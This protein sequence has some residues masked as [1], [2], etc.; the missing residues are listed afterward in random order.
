MKLK[1]LIPLWDTQIVDMQSTDAVLSSNQPERAGSV[2]V[3][4]SPWEGNC[5][6]FNVINDDGLYRM[7]YTNSKDGQLFCCYSQSTDGIHWEKPKLG[8]FNFGGNCDNN[9][10]GAYEGPVYV[11]K[12]ENSMCPP[13]E[14]YKA[15]Y[16]AHF[17]EIRCMFSADGIHFGNAR[18][19]ASTADY[20]ERI[21]NFGDSL[22]VLMWRPDSG[23][24]VCYLRTTDRRRF[25]PQNQNTDFQDSGRAIRVMESEDFVHW[26][27]PEE[28]RFQSAHDYELYCSCVSRYVYDKRYLIGFPV[29]YAER[30]RWTDNYAQ[31]C[32]REYRDL[33]RGAVENGIPTDRHAT[34]ITDCVFM[35][36]RDG[37]RWHRFDEA[38]ITPGPEQ[39]HKWVYGDCYCAVG[40][41]VTPARF[42]YEP[43]EIS[44][45]CEMYHWN[46]RPTE[47][48]RFV[49]RKDGFASFKAGYE[50]K[51]LQTKQFVLDGDA[52]SLNFRTSARGGVY[53][54][55]LD[56][57][58]Y[59]IPGYSSCEL[60]GDTLQRY[61]TFKKP[62]GKL[63]GQTVRL[64]LYLRDGEIYS[65]TFHE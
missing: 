61:V 19:L 18:V 49:Y 62:I 59:P 63:R 17:R 25:T 41:I 48:M 55:I 6:F 22:N 45:L 8:I 37:Y 10:I 53:V 27:V 64:Q 65:L 2:F 11:M 56:A 34:A 33:R 26:T 13:A 35:S 60:F 38:C 47:L 4:D 58:G 12:D 7:Y 30:I 39:P 21:T 46:T 43:E 28:I 24:Y 5:D 44:I 36:S 54:N 42:E 14:R 16:G 3:C 31:L 9:I 52:L 32:G 20:E 23:K 40:Q 29:R 57:D 15:I 50:F 51:T 1:G